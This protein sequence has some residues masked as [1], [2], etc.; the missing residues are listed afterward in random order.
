MSRALRTG[1]AAASGAAIAA[2]FP[3]LGLWPLAAFGV[4]GLALTVGGVRLRAALGYGLVAGCV[5]FGWTVQWISVVGWDAW[6]ALTLFTALPISATAGAMCLAM[7]LPGWPWLLGAVWVAQEAV[8]GRVPLGGWP[9]GRLAHGQADAPWLPLAAIGGTALLTFAVAVCGGLLAWAWLRLRDGARRRAAAVVAAVA[10]VPLLAALVPLPADGQEDGGPAAAVVAVVQGDVPNT[11]LG[12][13]DRTNRRAVLDNHVQQTFALAQ[14]VAAGDAPAPDAVIWPENA[15]DLDPFAAADARTAIGAAAKAI[16][17]P[18]LVGAVI[19]N[20]DDP[21]TVKNVGIVWDPT[22][23]PGQMYVKQHPVPFGEYVPLRPL[24]TRLIGRFDL[25]PRDFVAADEPG[26]LDVGP[27]RLGD[28]IC[29]EVAYDDL[30]RDTVLAGARM[31]AVQ[32]NNA[33]YTGSGQSEQQL[34]MARI[35]SV[36]HGRSVA[37]AATNGISALYLPDGST[38]GLLGESTSGWLTT[39]LPLR[40]SITLAD[41]LAFWPE[42]VAVAAAALIV[43]FGL[44]R[45]PSVRRAG[46]GGRTSHRGQV[47]GLRHG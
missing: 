47:A 37:V 12:F 24:L 22:Q 36:E 28:I 21:T 41:R 31:L 14:A 15:S 6:V 27:V 45:E 42:A 7:R 25:V 2:A 43:L 30:V 10:A 13:A 17:A 38:A 32:T 33:T 46:P 9:W 23:G 4:A 29:F 35:R 39:S 16:A 5:C 18:I 34:A 8:R 3:P 1:A 11:G 26:V 40:D 44:R 20:P 19:T